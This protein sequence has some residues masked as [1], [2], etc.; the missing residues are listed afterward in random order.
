MH[1]DTPGHH[2]AD[3]PGSCSDPG[4]NAMMRSAVRLTA[5][6]CVA[7]AGF[8]SSPAASNS[9]RYVMDTAN[10]PL[11]PGFDR[12]GSLTLTETGADSVL[13]SASVGPSNPE[14]FAVAGVW[15][16]VRGGQPLMFNVPGY[17]LSL[18]DVGGFGEFTFNV[19]PYPGSFAVPRFEFSVSRP[20]LTLSDVAFDNAD[21]WGAAMHIVEFAYMPPGPP[22]VPIVFEAIF[23]APTPVVPLPAPLLLLM[24]GLAALG[25]AVR[26]PA[27]S[28][29]IM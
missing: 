23:A 5:C 2:E 16:S 24:S 11:P 19:I 10:V 3:H 15:F 14:G 22:F 8:A 25:V 29:A 4:E 12:Y 13:F 26:R 17:I 27:A 20:G 28:T 18:G 21:G 6:L 1:I 7:M 9:V